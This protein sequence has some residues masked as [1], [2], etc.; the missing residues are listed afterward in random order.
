MDTIQYQLPTNLSIYLWFW[1]SAVTLSVFIVIKDRRSFALVQKSYW[2][3]LFEPWKLI[4]FFFATSIVG[5]AAPY[6]GDPTWDLANSI[7]ISTVVFI[8]APWSVAVLYRTIRSGKINLQLIVALCFL[9]LPCW[10]YDLYILL[11]D[12]TYPPTWYNN[13]YLSGAITIIAGLFWNLYNSNNHGLTFAFKFEKWPSVG[14]TPFR[15]VVVPC[16][17]LSLPMAA[18]IGWFVFM[19]LND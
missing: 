12:H 9:F 5:L 19:Y 16:F 14:T 4:S 7:I 18:S 17:L 11:R 6:S 15:K 13:L 2:I 3:F 1:L 8:F 10:T